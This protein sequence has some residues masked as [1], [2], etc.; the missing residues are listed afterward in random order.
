MK[1]LILVAIAFVAAAASGCVHIVTERE[2]LP[3]AGAVIGMPATAPNV[4]V[5]TGDGQILRGHSFTGEG[6]RIVVIYFGGNGEIIT[7]DNGIGVLA[8]R[9]EFDAYSLNYRGYG[10]S[11]GTASLDAIQEDS[12]RVFDDIAARPEVRGRPIVVVGASLGA[13]AALE[14][15]ASR[16]VAGVVLEG[17]PNAA[18]EV[19]PRMRRA[20]PWYS[21]MFVR[22]RAAPEVVARKPQPIDLAPLV[23]APL[24]S[25]HGTR[26]VIVA[27]RFGRKVFDAAGSEKKTFCAV[28]GAG[29]NDIWTSGIEGPHACLATFLREISSQPATRLL[30]SVP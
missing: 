16:P 11:G 20:L 8:K 29:H 28:D 30:C 13:A 27:I 12:L 1:R 26:D 2:L 7:A 21:R 17:A 10:S 19:V 3:G 18:R 5:A 4:E 14:V 22:L 9:H 15:A 24:L 23:T 6:R 25:I